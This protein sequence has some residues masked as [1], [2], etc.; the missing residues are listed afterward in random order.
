MTKGETI[1]DE[2]VEALEVIQV[3]NEYHTDAGLDVTLGRPSNV[4]EHRLPDALLVVAPQSDGPANE[5][6]GSHV[7][8]SHQMTIGIDGYVR[9]E[10]GPELAA[11][12]LL[13]DIRQALGLFWPRA[14]FTAAA[15]KIEQ[16]AA[17]IGTAEDG[18]RVSV[19]SLTVSVF[20]IENYRSVL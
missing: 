16:S 13:H 5:T 19:V 15:R 18:G 11:L 10:E 20:Y 12:R 9:S 3:A 8:G 14:Q 2:L 1:L 4:E 17:Q 7:T 6:D